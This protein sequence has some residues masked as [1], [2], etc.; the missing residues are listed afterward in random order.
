[1]RPACVAPV[2]ATSAETESRARE[3]V[4]YVY[5]RAKTTRTGVEYRFRATEAADKSDE[6]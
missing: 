3:P 4:V 6:S 1:M 2:K 5:D